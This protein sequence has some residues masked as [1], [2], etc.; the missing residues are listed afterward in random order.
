MFYLRVM[1]FSIRQLSLLGAWQSGAELTGSEELRRR[2]DRHRY[3]QMEAARLLQARLRADLARLLA[4]D[5]APRPLP[6]R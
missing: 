5:T 3:L 2:A 1:V 6:R 4:A